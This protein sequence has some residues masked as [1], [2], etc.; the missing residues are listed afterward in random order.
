MAHLNK[1]QVREAQIEAAIAAGK[2]DE[3]SQNIAVAGYYDA[4]SQKVI[5]ELA[6]GAEYRF[7]A[8]LGQG[9]D[10]ASEAELSHIEISPS[11]L[12][13][14]WPAID[15]GFSIPHL[16]EGIYGNKQWMSNLT[17]KHTPAK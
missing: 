7:P 8:R 17:V 15:V 10:Q 12:G 11:G 2:A 6:S 1:E 14:H 16:V 5:V 9:L 4:V 3:T 13:I